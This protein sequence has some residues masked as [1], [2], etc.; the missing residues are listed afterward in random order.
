MRKPPLTLMSLCLAL[1]FAAMLGIPRAVAQESIM[2]NLHVEPGQEWVQ[3]FEMQQDLEQTVM[4][5][6]MPMK[7]TIGMRMHST[8]TD[9][10]GEAGGRWIQMKY[11]RVWFKQAGAAGEL[12]YDS[13]DPPA[14]L[15]PAARGYAGLVGQQLQFEMTPDGRVTEVEG[16][17]ELVQNMVEALDLPDGPMKEA[18][19]QAMKGQ[20][21]ED[22]IKQMMSLATAIYPP[23][24]VAVGDS[25]EDRSMLGGMTPMVIDSTFTL[26]EFDDTTATLAVDGKLAPAPDAQPFEMNGM[27]M[28]AQLGGTQNGTTVLDR[29]T[30]L[31]IKSTVQQ[32]MSGTMS[33][34]T[35]QGQDMDIDMTV[36]STMTLT[37]QDPDAAP[38]KSQ[39]R[40]TETT[41]EATPA[42][43]Q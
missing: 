12:D 10:P 30:G 26:K 24:P 20:M 31:A 21:N 4:G 40:N 9:R 42:G 16:I 13:A 32:S 28:M 37:T 7:Q 8:V 19:T 43:A 34:T 33:M 23:K 22:S 27:K 17:D 14:E 5:Q 2:L 38:Q 11:T 25:W 41:P 1:S 29:D 39:D 15:A 36:E 6:K 35:P 18:A 3:D